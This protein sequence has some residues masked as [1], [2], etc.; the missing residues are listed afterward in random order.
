MQSKTM[1]PQNPKRT[2]RFLALKT[3][4]TEIQFWDYLGLDSGEECL[5]VLVSQMC[6]G[7]GASGGG[8]SAAARLSP[9]LVGEGEPCIRFTRR[10]LCIKTCK[11]MRNVH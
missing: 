9:V 6:P 11:R 2:P 5:E 10:H 3:S 4:C 1:S 7:S 8:E